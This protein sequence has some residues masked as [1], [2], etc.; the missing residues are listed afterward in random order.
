MPWF[1]RNPDNGPYY[2]SFHRSN[3]AILQ[4][5][6][7][8]FEYSHLFS[9]LLSERLSIV[10]PDETPVEFSHVLSNDFTLSSSYSNAD[11]HR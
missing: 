2:R 11:G 9:F 6:Q 3:L 7:L 5:L 8:P 1:D 4:P 10:F